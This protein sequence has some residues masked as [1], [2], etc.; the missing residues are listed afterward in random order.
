MYLII[1]GLSLGL[2][3]GAFLQINIPPELAR[4]TAV[5]IVGILDSLFGAIRATIEKKYSTTVF[6]SGLAFNMVIAVLITFIGDKLNLDLYLAILTAFIIRIL[7]NIG[8]IKTTAFGK[9][10]KQIG[11]ETNDEIGK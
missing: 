6:L 4:Y 3:I 5:A 9:I 7:A 2:L 10:W 11:T 8:V 1:L